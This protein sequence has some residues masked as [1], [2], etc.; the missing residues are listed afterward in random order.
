MKWA[1]QKSEYMP[2]FWRD[3]LWVIAVIHPKNS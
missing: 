2:D 1:R 3:S